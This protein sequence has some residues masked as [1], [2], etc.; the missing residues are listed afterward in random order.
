LA[1]A[2]QRSEGSSLGPDD[3]VERFSTVIGA[4]YRTVVLPDEHGLAL[5]RT[6]VPDDCPLCTAFLGLAVLAAYTMQTQGHY[7][8]NDYYGR[9]RDL[10]VSSPEGDDSLPF[11]QADYY[12]LWAYLQ[13]WVSIKTSRAFPLPS[14]DDTTRFYVDLA[15]SHVPLRKVDIDRLPAFFTFAE[16][17][18]GQKPPPHALEAAL[19]QWCAGRQRFTEAGT[20]ALADERRPAILSQVSHE[21]RIWDGR[22]KAISTSTTGAVDLL[23]DFPNSQPHLRFLA[24]C[25]EGFPV[26]FEDGDLLL[27]TD[28]GGW[29]QPLRVSEAD[30]PRLTEGFSWES[31]FE[32]TAYT[33]RRP[34]AQAIAFAS[35]DSQ[36]HGTALVS[37]G[38]LLLGTKC[39]VLCLESLAPAA[40]QYL[41]QV[42][43]HECSPMKPPGFPQGWVLFAGLIC[44]KA[45]SPPPELQALTPDS[46]V[47]IHFS[48]GLRVDGAYLVGGPPRISVSGASGS[49]TQVRIGENSLALDPEGVVVG[50]PQFLREG[51][52]TVSAGPRT[53]PITMVPSDLAHGLAVSPAS[54]PAKRKFS[55]VIGL[56]HG[57]WYPVGAGV[58]EVGEPGSDTPQGVLFRC[59]FEPVWA[60]C[61]ANR[62]SPMVVCLSASPAPP[63]PLSRKLLARLR[64]QRK[65][66]KLA[67][68]WAARIRFTNNHPRLRIL[69][70]HGEAPQP[71]R[72]AWLLLKSKAAQVARAIRTS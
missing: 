15:L 64:C 65:A 38:G 3:A 8:A 54:P 12:S 5:L 67:A 47:Q 40:E 17:A 53:R 42:T 62:R 13:K 22:E 23:L 26:D 69:D 32:G 61:C 28:G 58:G 2:W 39:A 6:T 37:G 9:L 41:T 27:Q 20:S 30:G 49:A 11:N 66:R 46:S 44:Q 18:P 51:V 10:L 34:P 45:L 21:L 63:E 56:P 33:L 35:R 36:V 1:A 60:V 43:A 25:P 29:Y 71:T 4:L 19:D 57:L 16:Y 50:A 52:H 59:D 48:G 31:T 55:T 72:D 68:R 24:R 70:A 14:R 7:S